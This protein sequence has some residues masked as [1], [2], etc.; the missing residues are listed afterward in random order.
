M[1][2]RDLQKEPRDGDDAQATPSPLPH[3]YDNHGAERR[4]G[5]AREE[6]DSQRRQRRQISVSRRDWHPGT[7]REGQDDKC[8]RQ[9]KADAAV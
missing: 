2:Q 6:Q 5:H 1:G 9:Q 4:R 7:S 3:G 8:G